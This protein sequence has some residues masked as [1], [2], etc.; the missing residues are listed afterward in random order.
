MKTN[1]KSELKNLG[2]HILNSGWNHKKPK[3]DYMPYVTKVLLLASSL[4]LAPT[5]PPLEMQW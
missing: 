5:E 2:K 1:C 3:I 4:D